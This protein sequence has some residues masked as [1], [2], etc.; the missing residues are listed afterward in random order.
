MRIC[1]RD[2]NTSRNFNRVQRAQARNRMIDFGF[3]RAL[4]SP[5]TLLLRNNDRHHGICTV[6]HYG[7]A[8]QSLI[9]ISMSMSEVSP[10]DLSYVTSNNPRQPAINYSQNNNI[11]PH[12]E[13][14][15][16]TSITIPSLTRS[17]STFASSIDQ[18]LASR[19][20]IGGR[21]FRGNRQ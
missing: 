21:A 16:V 20:Y 3:L 8:A 19:R 2:I 5:L 7:S 1:E 9:T 17:T 10:R 4:P 6:V 14:S 15:F 13:A 11:I 12:R 18:P